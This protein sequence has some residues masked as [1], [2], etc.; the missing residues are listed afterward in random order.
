[1]HRPL[2]LMDEPTVSLDQDAAGTVVELVRE[3]LA[4]G[5]AALIA[6]HADLGL[7]QIPELRMSPPEPVGPGA[8]DPF[9][10]GSW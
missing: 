2:W 10:E 1:V 5:G 3:H 8:Q 7:G 6:T 4:G 9:L